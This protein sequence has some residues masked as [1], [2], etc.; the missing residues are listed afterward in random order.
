MVAAKRSAKASNPPEQKSG[1]A[2][3]R[4]HALVFHNVPELLRQC[5]VNPDKVFRA[6]GLSAEDLAS[7]DRSM[8]FSDADRLLT[9][10]RQATKCPHFGLLIGQQAGLNELGLPGRLA[11]NAATVGDAMR[12]LMAHFVL[13]DTGGTPSVSIHGDTVSFGYGIHTPGF[14]NLDQVYDLSAA[15]AYNI[16]KELCGPDWRPDAILLP[17]ARPADIGPYRRYFGAPLKFDAARQAIVFGVSWLTRPI[18]GADPLVRELIENRA[19]ETISHPD[20][21]LEADVRRVIHLLLISSECSRESVARRLGMHHRSLSRRLRAIGTTYQNL[22]DE[23]RFDLAQQLLCDTRL[24]VARV[25]RAVGFADP[26][27][28]TR[29]FRRWSGQTPREFRAARPAA[30]SSHWNE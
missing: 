8:T 9:A 19:R 10:C 1:P 21:V 25:S 15:V 18:A 28:F 29:A 17:R 14:V 22:Y 13:H 4:V 11:R 2:V 5:G 20:P 3:A 26:T 7:P 23:T 6:A 27:I 24:P 12:D 16:L 30:R